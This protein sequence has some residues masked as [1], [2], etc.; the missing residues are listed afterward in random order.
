[1]NSQNDSDPG[2]APKAEWNLVV[3]GDSS[4]WG[5]GAAMAS[6]IEKNIDVQV[7]LFDFALGIKMGYGT[8]QK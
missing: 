5:V 7:N 8:T 1:M 2:I 6:Q 4:L 3:I